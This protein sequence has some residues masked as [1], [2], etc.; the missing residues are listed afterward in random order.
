MLPYPRFPPKFLNLSWIAPQFVAS[1]LIGG[2]SDLFGRRPLL[3]LSTAGVAASYAVWAA[4]S[5]FKIFVIARYVSDHL[6]PK[7]ARSDFQW[8]TLYINFQCS[9]RVS[10]WKLHEHEQY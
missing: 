4:A 9:T 3:L 10:I 5:S 7:P 8:D 2:M 1:P 6:E